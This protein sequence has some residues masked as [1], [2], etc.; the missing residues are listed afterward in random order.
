MAEDKGITIT[1][2]TLFEISRREK[3][4]LE[5]QKLDASFLNDVVSYLKE[6]RSILDSKE[7][8]QGFFSDDEKSKTTYQLSNIK[9]ILKELYERREKK[10]INLALD[11]SKT[12]SDLID[13]SN[14][15]DHE[16]DMF[17]SLLKL[18]DSYRENVLIRLLNTQL[19]GKVTT[20]S[21]EKKDEV[22]ELHEMSNNAV[23]L[24]KDSSEE[25]LTKLIRFKHAVP[26]F[27][28][29]EG[30]E[31]GPFEEEDIAS[32]PFQIANVL[33]TK[34]RADQINEE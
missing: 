30:E 8:Q 15:L 7:N 17:D 20:L 1:Y 25:R 13:M 26:K 31:F 14:L 24:N 21:V 4:R 34:G 27:L 32:L 22:Q 33:I 9:K 18:L 16:I 2:E 28:G 3:D 23:G 12:K 6:K 19:P 29:L 11:K 10:I 5:L